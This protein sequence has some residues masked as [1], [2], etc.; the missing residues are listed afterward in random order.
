MAQIL[1]GKWVRDEILKE[2]KPRVQAMTA[3]RRQPGLA[4]I[5]V[6]NDPASEIYVRNK[7]RACAEMGIYSEK[8][9]PPADISTR[10]LLAL[11]ESLNARV[12]IDGILIQTPLP[13]QIDTRQVL[14]AVRPDKDVD[15]FHPVNVGNL[16]ANV[17]GPRPC[18][19]AGVIQLLKRYEIP[20]AGRHAV[21]IG[22]S[23]IVG[24]PMA[25]LLLHEN[26]TVTICHSRTANLVTESRRADILVTA[27]GR[28]AMVTRD[29]I[30]P[31]A[32]VIDVGMN[33]ITDPALSEAIFGDHPSRSLI[34]DTH[35]VD[36]MEAAG[37][38]TPVPGGVGPLTIAMLMVNTVRAAELHLGCSA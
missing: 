18:T 32:T 36:V 14:V 4:V 15:G 33:R 28:P 29:Y 7:E 24:K 23:D 13:S 20:I 35:P 16:V 31:G 26:A 17:P 25:L 27:I 38:Y 11:I 1:D 9:T 22:R 6:G 12:E 34:G 3:Q 30:K 5:L 8:Y 2:W 21:V 10:E 37:A 19:P